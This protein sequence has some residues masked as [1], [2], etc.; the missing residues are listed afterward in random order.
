MQG[1]VRVLLAKTEKTGLD[2]VQASIFT[3]GAGFVPL[4]LI[5]SVDPIGSR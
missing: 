3:L 1:P 2:P 4:S 5:P